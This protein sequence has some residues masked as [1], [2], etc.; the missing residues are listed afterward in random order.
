MCGAAVGLGRAEKVA[1]PERDTG[2]DG[3]LINQTAIDANQFDADNR[4]RL[5]RPDVEAMRSFRSAAAQA[6]VEQVAQFGVGGQP[7]P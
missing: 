7:G 5:G 2:D 4:L 6:V 3:L 1:L